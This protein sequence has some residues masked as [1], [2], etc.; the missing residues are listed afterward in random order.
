MMPLKP[1]KYEQFDAAS[2]PPGPIEISSLAILHGT[3]EN[4]QKSFQKKKCLP[5]QHKGM[6]V[7][8]CL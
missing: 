6:L 1:T 2:G 4:V 8:L 5:F 3:F 7:Q